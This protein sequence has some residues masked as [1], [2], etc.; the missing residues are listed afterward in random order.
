MVRRR[1]HS[2]PRNTH[3]QVR[4]RYDRHGSPDSSAAGI[5]RYS[6]ARLTLANKL[7]AARD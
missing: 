5:A 2:M 3:Q 6:P 4:C 1:V 7:A